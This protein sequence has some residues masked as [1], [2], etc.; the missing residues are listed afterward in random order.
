M[1]S[2]RILLILLAGL[3]LL[4]ILIWP[5]A[6]LWEKLGSQVGCLLN[7]AGSCAKQQVTPPQPAA[8]SIPI[9]FDDD[10]SPDGI[11]ALLYFLH[12]PRFDV[13]AVTISYGETHPEQFAPVIA[14]ILA[15]FGR[16]DIPVGYG[17][18]T[19]LAGT[20]VYPEQWRQ[21]SVAFWGIPY[22]RAA[23][24]QVPVP[25]PQLMVDV[26]SRSSRPLTVFASGAHTTLA[27]ALRLDPGI[28]RNI[29]GVFIMG[30]SIYQPG[31]IHHD[32]PAYANETAEWNIW[33]DPAAASEVFASGLSLYL[34]P[35]DATNKVVWTEADAAHWAA[36]KSP[37]S[38]LAAA[39]LRWML[40]NLGPDGVYNW[41]LTAAIDNDRT[42]CPEVKLDVDVV[43]APG[44]D[45]GRTKVVDGSPNVFVCLDP[46]AA[47]F[48]AQALSIFQNP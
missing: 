7:G 36:S 27:E 21:N 15:A 8:G 43:T 17:R 19:P 45:L 47:R 48:K 3:L 20:N 40:A 18:D 41:D 14:Q 26:L 22:P 42:L 37:Q 38:A 46:D 10:A 28:A 44:P 5:M 1:K 33:S 29:A 13:K 4:V 39:L 11:I 34:V 25:A 2:K 9:I 16:A 31:N 35:L 32:W 12:N 24:A 6:P 23:G 30:G